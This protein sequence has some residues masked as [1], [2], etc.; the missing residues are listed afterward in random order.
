V[1]PHALVGIAPVD[2]LHVRADLGDGAELLGD[3][4]AQRL[5]QRLSGLGLAAGEFPEAGEMGAGR[6]ARDEDPALALDDRRHD[7]DGYHVS[8]WTSSA[9]GNRRRATDA[10]G[11]ARWGST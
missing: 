7:L 9:R 3:L 1:Q 5:L 4:A 8:Q 6:A 2:G 11:V 10:G